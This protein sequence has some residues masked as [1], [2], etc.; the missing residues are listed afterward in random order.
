MASNRHLAR[1]LLYGSVSAAAL[2]VA[3]P[4]A[5]ADDS[6]PANQTDVQAIQA[7]VQQLQARLKALKNPDGEA[8]NTDTQAAITAVPAP[9]QP[10][11]PSGPKAQMANLAD[12]GHAGPADAVV[13]GDFPGSW[14]LPG[15]NTSM[16]IHGYVKA[17]FIYDFDHA[18]GDSFNWSSLP[19]KGTIGAERGRGDAR[20][21][22]RQTRIV[23]DTET[24][25]DYGQLHTRITGDFFGAGS[26]PGVRAGNNGFGNAF[27]TNSYLFR[28]FQAYAQ[29]GPVLVGHTYTLFMNDIGGADTIDFNGPAGVSFI[30]Q[31]GVRWVQNFGKF[32]LAVAAENPQ[33]YWTTNAT[34]SPAIAASVPGAAG[35]YGNDGWSLQTIPDFIARAEYND[36]WG[37]LQLSGV[38]QHNEIDSGIPIAV[39][40]H[41][42]KSSI[43]QFGVLGAIWLKNFWGSDTFG[44]EATYGGVGRY[45][46]GG[47]SNAENGATLVPTPTLTSMHLVGNDI[48]GFAAYYTHYWKDDL[49]ST[50]AYG[51]D[52]TYWNSMAGLIQSLVTT[53]QTGHANL[54]WSPVKS[55]DVGLEV[56]YAR[57]NY[58]GHIPGNPSTIGD[59]LRLQVG[60]TAKF[61]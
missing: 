18:A 21:H 22:V 32:Q 27:V 28:L 40:G 60:A 59:D 13:G 6:Q 44:A 48:L 15:S 2:L 31:A 45:L 58:G 9:P 16:G 46:N 8:V 55:V 36:T 54:I 11:G 53:V 35:T 7:R 23:F 20:F 26:G 50:L 4:V 17:D 1:K 19:R 30:R 56:S 14:K 5:F 33:D 43:Q 61:D 24:P 41:T 10:A 42:Q 38:T 49:R 3:A 29:L 39:F 47:G 52:H 12:K 57:D 51:R 34:A 25:T 37:S